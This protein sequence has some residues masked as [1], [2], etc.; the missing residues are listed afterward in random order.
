MSDG[1]WICPPTVVLFCSKS[2]FGDF[3]AQILTVS[4]AFS[5]NRSGMRWR[6]GPLVERPGWKRS[7]II[8]ASP[9]A[10]ALLRTLRVA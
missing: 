3:A 10:A 1:S 5:P 4:A 2:P 8:S 7:C 9:W 6:A